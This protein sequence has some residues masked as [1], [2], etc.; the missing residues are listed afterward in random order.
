[1]G[2][3]R[4]RKDGRH[5]DAG[6]AGD[7]Y[8]EYDDD[9]D[10]DAA[11]SYADEGYAADGGYDRVGRG[12]GGDLH[13]E[14][15]FEDGPGSEWH[16]ATDT[17]HG[18]YDLADAPDDGLPRLDLGSVRIPVPDDAQLQIELEQD[19]G[20]IRAVNVLTPLG[21]FTINA[22]AAPRSGG[23]WTEVK[24]ELAQQLAN[25]GARVGRTDG[26]W[27]QELT[28]LIDDVALRLIGVDGPRW[29]L[30]GVVAGPQA[31]AVASAEALRQLLRRT[32]VVRGDAPLPVRTPLPVELP[33]EVAQQLFQAQQPGR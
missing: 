13:E 6:D 1:M 31:Q 22:Y 23:L 19:S 29:L 7:W 21:Q 24:G 28:G 26:E 20:A 5:H 10:D 16:E 27:G 18:P 17:A 15:G 12:F 2:I 25:D 30:R 33:E 14:G 11:E 9:L 3:F 32:I 8:D 4:R